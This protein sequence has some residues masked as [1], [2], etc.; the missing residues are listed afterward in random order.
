MKGDTD[1]RFQ[2]G[3]K[4]H[5]ILDLMGLER[6]EEARTVAQQ[7]LG[8]VRGLDREDDFRVHVE[9]VRRLVAPPINGY[10]AKRGRAKALERALRLLVKERS[11]S[12]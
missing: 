6:W 2:L 11:P 4:R 8:E 9:R 10:K 7:L 12:P 3:I 5:N 1:L